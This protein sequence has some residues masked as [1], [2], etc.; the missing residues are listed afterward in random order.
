VNVGAAG[1][2]CFLAGLF[3]SFFCPMKWCYV[4]LLKLW[5]G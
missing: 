4:S 2:S 3:T 5:Y 1:H